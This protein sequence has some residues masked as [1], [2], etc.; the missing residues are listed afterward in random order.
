MSDEDII[1]KKLL[2]DPLEL[3][4]DSIMLPKGFLTKT[5]LVIPTED[6]IRKVLSGQFDPKLM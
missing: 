4:S 6:E 1:I 2:V 3:T 5:P